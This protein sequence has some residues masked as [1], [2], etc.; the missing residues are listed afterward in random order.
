M[1][2]GKGNVLLIFYLPDLESEVNFFSKKCMQDMIMIMLNA[3]SPLFSFF[4]NINYDQPP[5]F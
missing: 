3:F 5:L 4:E 2:F 1:M